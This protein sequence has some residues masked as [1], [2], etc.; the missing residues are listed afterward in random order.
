MR[1]SLLDA[2]SSG[3]SGGS[4]SARRPGRSKG[5]QDPFGDYFHEGKKIKQKI[6]KQLECSRR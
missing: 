4:G 3:S 2:G 6:F 1:P 5:T